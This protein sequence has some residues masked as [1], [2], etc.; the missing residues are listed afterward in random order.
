MAQNP[1]HPFS[2][3]KSWRPPE[4]W[5][6]ITTLDVHT[7]GEPLRVILDGF[8][9]PEG[10]TMLERRRIA[11]ERHDVP[12]A[13]LMLEPRGHADMYGCLLVPPVSAPSCSSMPFL[14]LSWGGAP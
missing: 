8:P 3:A 5:R 13:A 12:R 10:E 14:G 6:K 1:H 4:G 2:Q 9:E 7:E 11:K